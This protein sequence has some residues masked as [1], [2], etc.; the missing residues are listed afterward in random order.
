MPRA[1][2]IEYEW[3]IY[4]VMNRGDRREDIFFGSED[5]RL[6][7]KTLKEA[8]GKIHWQVHA[9]CLMSNHF[10]LVLETPEPTLVSGM[11]WMQGT[12]T[13]Q[14]NVRHRMRGHLFAGRYKV[15]LVDETEAFLSSDSV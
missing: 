5:R 12:Y 7:L 10:H 9:Y 13:Q 11:K 3:A 8:C 2:R 4:H 1:L 15:L 6:F 14:F